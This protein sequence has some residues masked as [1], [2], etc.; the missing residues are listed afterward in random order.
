MASDT[1]S[2][3]ATPSGREVR[4]WSHKKLIEWLD[5][6]LPEGILEGDQRAAFVAAG[7]TGLAF[8]DADKEFYSECGLSLGGGRHLLTMARDISGSSTRDVGGTTISQKRE[9]YLS[10]TNFKYL[11][12]IDY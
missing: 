3:Y 2:Q 6:V 5:D 9:Y 10:N 1:N 8:L 12:S 7:I 4:S 11:C